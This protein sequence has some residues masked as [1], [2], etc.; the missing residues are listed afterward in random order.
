MPEPRPSAAA[1][2]EVVAVAT[3]ADEEESG[4]AEG[5]ARAAASV[6]ANEPNPVVMATV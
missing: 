3:A 5:V 4:Y 2:A 6:V 1:V